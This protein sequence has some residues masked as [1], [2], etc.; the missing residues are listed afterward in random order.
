MPRKWKMG[1]LRDVGHKFVDHLDKTDRRALPFEKEDLKQI[2]N[3]EFRL[4]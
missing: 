4:R 1:E 2:Y 3:D